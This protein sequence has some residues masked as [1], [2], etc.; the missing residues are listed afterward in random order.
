MRAEMAA[1]GAALAPAQRHARHV[2][3][4]DI[5]DYRYDE[6]SQQ[7]RARAHMFIWRA[8]CSGMRARRTAR[9]HVYACRV[10]AAAARY[11]MQR[12]L[13]RA[14]HERTCRYL[15]APPICLPLCAVAAMRR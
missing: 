11:F 7:R 2:V 3:M 9:K 6:R 14:H 4:S 5:R 10:A 8:A 1:S 12:G 15:I 13:R